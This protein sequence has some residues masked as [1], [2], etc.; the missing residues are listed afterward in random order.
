MFPADDSGKHVPEFT[1]V[2]VADMYASS[3]EV[4]QS[5]FH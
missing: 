3:E 2:D 4:Y 5:I 1:P